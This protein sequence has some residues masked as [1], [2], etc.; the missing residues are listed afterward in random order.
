MKQ[1]ELEKFPESDSR[2]T[3][4]NPILAEAAATESSLETLLLSIV[5]GLTG[6]GQSENSLE[7]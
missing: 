3:P 2:K 5:T 6:P 7:V 1:K 4:E